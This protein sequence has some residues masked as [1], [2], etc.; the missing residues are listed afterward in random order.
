[1]KILEEQHIVLN[2]ASKLLKTLQVH[3]KC[4][5]VQR[6]ECMTKHTGGH[7]NA[8]RTSSDEDPTP[9][10]VSYTHLDVYKRQVL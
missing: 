3:W 6:E 1:M 9:G 4:L 2:F 10:P 7:Y 8:C 5:E